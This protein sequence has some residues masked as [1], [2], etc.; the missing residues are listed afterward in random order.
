MENN[1]PTAE[2]FLEQEQFY[3]VTSGDEYVEGFY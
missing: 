1:I 3:A 2:E